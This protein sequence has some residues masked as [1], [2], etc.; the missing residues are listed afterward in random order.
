[1]LFITRTSKKLRPECQLNVEQ[2]FDRTQP[3]SGT[4]MQRK[5]GTNDAGRKQG[6]NDAL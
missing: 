6:D 5:C 1:M 3:R 2:A 4:A